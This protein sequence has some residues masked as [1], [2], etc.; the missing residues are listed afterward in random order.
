[1]KF[2]IDEKYLI[3]CFR[4]L[5]DVPS[6]VC[7]GEKI[8]PLLE[9]MAAEMGC[10][11][12]YDRRGNSYITL[13]GEDNSKT[14][15]VAAH[16]DTLGMVV[17][18]VD[19]DGKIRVRQLGG[20][21]Y[22]SLEGESVTVHTRSGKE[23]T[24]LIA[25]QSH[26]VHVFD[27]ARTLERNENTMI[28]LL[29]EDV[30]SKEDVRALGILNGDFISVDPRCEFTSTG[31]LKSR[32]IDDKA[33]VACVFAMIR[34]LKENGLKPRYRTMLAFTF[35]EEIG[36]GGPWVPEEVSEYVAIDIG[37]IGPDYEGHE[38]CVTIC[39]KDN[40]APYTYEL[41]NRLIDYARKAECDYAVDIFYRY[42][43]DASVALATSNNL[44]AAAFGMPVYCSHGRERTHVLS[45]QNTT[46]LLLAYVLDI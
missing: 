23:Y 31:Y 4:R 8:N 44:Q 29:D 37:L 30:H 3:D 22:C 6:P 42:G 27:D 7:Y 39:A 45:L 46:N 13:E 43:T 38:R 9:E 11:L 15:L 20:V 19:A 14:V 36:L 18:R 25:C 24:G 41:T 32:F 21:N 35:G 34:H 1:M 28:V 12:T 5:V 2:Q 17:R 10:E 40:K 16:W 33:A 26:S